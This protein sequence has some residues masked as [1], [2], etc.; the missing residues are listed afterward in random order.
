MEPETATVILKWGTL[1]GWENMS[2][3][4]M[5]LL[6]RYY[7]PGVSMGCAT[8]RDDE[9]QKQILIELIGLPGMKIY[10]DWDGRYVKKDEGI[11]YLKGYPNNCAASP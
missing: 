7:E 2:E 3:E 11:A 1:K 10:L 9:E 6:K 5:K 4:G 8:Q